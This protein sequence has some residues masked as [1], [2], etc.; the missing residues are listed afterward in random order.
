M[1][2]TFSYAQPT[3][4]TG[5]AFENETTT[6]FTWC[7]DPED[8][9]LLALYDKGR[10]EQWEA[11][12]RLDWSL[13]LDPENPM[14]LADDAIPIFGTPVWSRLTAAEQTNVRRH[15]QA[16]TLSQFLHGEQGA[17][18][19]T[20]KIIDM[21]PSMDAKLCAATQVIDEARHVGIFSRLLRDKFELTYPITPSLRALLQDGLS[22][23]RWDMV[24]LSMQVLIEGLA[25]A[26]FQRIRDFST[27]PL[28]SRIHAYV[29]QDE[30]R[31][32]AFGRA[33][34]AGLYTEFTEG[35]RRERVEFVLT[36]CE[37]LL[38]RFDQREMWETLG[39]PVNECAEATRQSPM[40]EALRVQLFTRI[41]P[42]LKHIGL[43][44]ANL[45]HGLAQ[46]GVLSAF[47]RDA[48]AM[49]NDDER[50]ARH[51]ETSSRERLAEI[52]RLFKKP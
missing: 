7:Y 2:I 25:L 21:A 32:V 13:D 31:H 36:A 10:R 33:A 42:S 9:P 8:G 52:R 16:F 44:D 20:A 49:L 23:G 50:I 40:M 34:L 37:Q 24:Y 47:D 27:N 35:E 51:F 22:D 48:Q 6:R 19:A 28:I 1:S 39:L 18:I 45:Q 15:H 11:A 38:D 17:L 4:E 5:W 12:S 43:W 30:A 46:L 14:A 26:S 3:A 29:M 41:V